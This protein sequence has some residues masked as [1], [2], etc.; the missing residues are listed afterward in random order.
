M[1][2]NLPKL[3]RIDS[4][5]GRLY[6]TPDGPFPSITTVLGATSDNSYLDEWRERVGKEEADRVSR[7]A[8]TRGSALHGY[9][10]SYLLNLPF[11]VNMFDTH[12][13]KQFK[14]ILEQIEEVH[15]IEEAI[16]SKDFKIAGT[17]DLIAKHD[18]KLKII[19][20][21]TSGK[22]KYKEDIESY[23]IQCCFY[24]IAFY[25]LTN[26]Y[27]DSIMIVIACDETTKPLVF[28]DSVQNWIPK[29]KEVRKQFKIIKG[30]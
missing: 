28:E 4:P 24:S 25:Y 2:Y 5:N 3:N 21:K 26:I 9:C 1:K 18:G 12:M 15:L 16:Y 11:E 23:F 17:V 30:I 7:R 20:W 10:E 19:D 8:T 6:E 22:I 13:F 27:V 14:L 29:L